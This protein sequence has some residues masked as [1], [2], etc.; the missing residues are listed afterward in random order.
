MRP[1]AR[2]AQRTAVNFLRSAESRRPP[3]PRQREPAPKRGQGVRRS[4]A[5]VTEPELCAD[6]VVEQ[7]DEEGL[8]E[9]AQERQAEAEAEKASVAP[10]ESR[11]RDRV[12]VRGLTD[13]PMSSPLLRAFRRRLTIP[14]PLTPAATS[15]STGSCQ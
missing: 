14:T 15:G 1:A 12:R 11:I 9:R 2:A 8:T 10:D 5:C 7:R 4:D 6:A 3:Y 13:P